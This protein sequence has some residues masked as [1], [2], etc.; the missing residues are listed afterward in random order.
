MISLA[1]A[2]FVT[3]IFEQQSRKCTVSEM[4]AIVMKN[5]LAY[6]YEHYRFDILEPPSPC[7]VVA[8]RIFERRDHE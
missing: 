7:E 8:K 3:L 1:C 4:E 5:P 6:I 2:K